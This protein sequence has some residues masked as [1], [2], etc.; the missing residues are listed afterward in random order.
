MR[1]RQIFLG[2]WHIH[3]KRVTLAAERYESKRSGNVV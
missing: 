2:I 3:L 1:D